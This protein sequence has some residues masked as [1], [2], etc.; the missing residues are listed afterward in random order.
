MEMYELPVGW[1]WCNLRELTLPKEVW[2][3]AKNPRSTFR[4]IDISCID[5][6]AGQIGDVR[7]IAGADAPSRAKRIVRKGDVLF[8]TTRPNLKNIA[9]VP[10]VLDGEICSTGFCVLRPKPSPTENAPHATSEWLYFACRSDLIVDQVIPNQEKSTYPAVSDD[11]VL[12]AHI[13]VAPLDE[14]RRIIARIEELTRRIRQA[15]DIQAEASCAVGGLFQTGLESAFAEREIADWRIYETKQLFSPVNGQVDPREEP[16]ADMPHV[17][18]DSIEIGTCRLLPETIQ[19]P[20]QLGLKS[21][22][23]PFRPEHVLYSKIR[24][25][26]RKVAL[27]TFAGVCSADMYPLLPNTEIITREFLALSLLSPAFSQYAVDHSDRN[28]MPKI[29]RK[30]LFAFEMPVPEKAIQNQ[31][32]DE[33]FGMQKK[34]EKLAEM[35]QA[36][37]KELD[38]FTPALL[39]KAFCGEL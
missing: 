9:V 34:S 36:I 10:T 3:Q 30:T 6:S 22:K 8:A 5:N 33:L 23:Y 35:Q 27:P 15:I 13:P 14:Q 7:E 17:G 38:S 25:A 20:R 16:Y 28:A 21:G 31:I 37:A 19:T 18:P 32:T 2:N 39:A 11:E 12:A 29:N 4:Y 1:A 24:P 26:L